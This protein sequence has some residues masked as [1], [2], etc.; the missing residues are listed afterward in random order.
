MSI[1][2]QPGERTG[3]NGKP[4]SNHVLLSLTAPQFRSLRQHLR[5]LPMTHHNIL[6]DCHRIVDTIFF[7]NDGLVSQVIVMENGRTAEAG[8]IGN[9]GVIGL[10]GVF[11]VKRSSIREIV[12][13]SGTAYSIRA[14][15]LQKVVLSVPDILL[16]F[17]RFAIINRMQVSQ[18]AACN[19]LHEVDKRLARWL[20]MTQDRVQSGL[21]TMTHDFLATMLGTDRGSVTT[22]AG[23]LHKH[24][25]IEYARGSVRVLNRK[26]LEECACECYGLIREYNSELVR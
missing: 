13:V 2:L 18:T 15:M 26:A 5:F 6:H 14:A 1:V 3:P 17:S 12:Q 19:R 21:L 24:K 8:V 23:V 10:E 4:V 25:V 9:E 20:L 16:G 7:P 22:A 11:G